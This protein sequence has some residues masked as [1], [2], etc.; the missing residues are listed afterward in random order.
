MEAKV[1]RDKIRGFRDGDE[2][3]NLGDKLLFYYGIE[4][5]STAEFGSAT[6]KFLIYR[7]MIAIK[8]PNPASQDCANEDVRVKNDHVSG[9]SAS[10]DAAF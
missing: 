7:S 5:S 10:R 3:P 6:E 2:L 4:F 9:M 1:A 8:G